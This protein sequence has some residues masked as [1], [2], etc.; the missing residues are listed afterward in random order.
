MMGCLGRCFADRALLSLLIACGIVLFVTMPAEITPSDTFASRSEA[1]HLIN[2]HVLGFDY[3]CRQQPIGDFLQP[4]K[5]AYFFE[6]DD[7]QMFFSKYGIMD[8][9]M[10]V[11]PLFA[12]YLWAGRV[13]DLDSD[14]STVFFLNLN[15]IILA[16]ICI[17]YLYKLVGL[18]CEDRLIKVIY[19]LASVF[20]TYLWFFLRMHMHEIFQLLFFLGFFYHAALFL[21]ASRQQHPSGPWAHLLISAIFLGFLVLTKIFF[22]VIMVS[23]VLIVLWSGPENLLLRERVQNHLC[24]HKKHIGVCLI[25]PLVLFGTVQL[26]VNHYK[27]GSAWDAAYTQEAQSITGANF[28]VK[29]LGDSIPGYFLRPGNTNVFLYYPPLILALFGMVPFAKRWRD[30]LFL[31]LVVVCPG[32]MVLALYE[33]WRGEWT[34]GPRYLLPLAVVA[35]LPALEAIGGLRRQMG[36]W[37]G[38]VAAA[39]AVVVL[40]WSFLLQ[41]GVNSVDPWAFYY[42]QEVLM[43]VGDQ[44]I[45]DYFN[46]YLHRGQIY[47]DILAYRLGWPGKSYYPVAVVQEKYPE[48]HAASSFHTALLIRCQPN[49]FFLS[50]LFP[51]RVAKA[52]SP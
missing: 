49:Y 35:S 2:H 52:V 19:V 39:V 38:K 37:Y 12:E 33:G 44:E 14:R 28:S 22:A 31:I 32:L 17:Y 9:L 5:G 51:E 43:A 46:S 7:K 26:C 40:A 36:S 25:L 50:F 27:T 23:A 3:S 6:N 8:T 45:D 11:P 4:L 48:I 20:C 13:A 41:V 18:Y 1:A 42:H 29:T 34:Y 16:L 10:Y 15:N 24:C 30:D 21:K 47:L